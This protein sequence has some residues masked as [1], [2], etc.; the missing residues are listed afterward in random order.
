MRNVSFGYQINAM[1]MTDKGNQDTAP[2]YTATK[3]APYEVSAVT[4]PAD[5][6][7]GF[8]RDMAD[9]NEVEVIE[10]INKPLIN[11]TREKGE[12]TMEVNE[13]PVKKETIDVSKFAADAVANERARIAG[14]NALV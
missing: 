7:V 4:V 8:G 11:Q 5:A 1:E 6:S 3:W 9:E 13:T 12:T 10:I 2:S 14:I